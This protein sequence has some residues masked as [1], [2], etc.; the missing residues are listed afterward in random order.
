MN[1]TFTPYHFDSERLNLYKESELLPLRANE[2][3]LLS[4]LLS[5]TSRI[6]SKQEIL[7]YVWSDK[8]VSEQG[9]FQS[10]STLRTML[11]ETSIKTFPRRGYQW[12][13]PVEVEVPIASPSEPDMPKSF[14]AQ[15]FGYF[16]E[17]PVAFSLLGVAMIVVVMTFAYFFLGVEGE[18]EELPAEPELVIALLPFTYANDGQQFDGKSAFLD[19][20]S[21]RVIRQASDYDGI[22]F[23]PVTSSL[24]LNDLDIDPD[25]AFKGITDKYN[26]D[27]LLSATIRRHEADYVS[28]FRLLGNR[29]AWNGRITAANLPALADKLLSNIVL[30]SSAPLLLTDI[31]D[32]NLI[33]AQLRLLHNQR[34][35]NLIVILRLSAHLHSLGD[36]SSAVILA[37]KLLALAQKNNEPFYSALARLRLTYGFVEQG[38]LEKAKLFAEEAIASLKHTQDLQLYAES[39]IAKAN[40]LDLEGNYS[41]SMDVMRESLDI[42]QALDL[43]LREIHLLAHMAAIAHYNK[44]PEE[45]GNWLTMA[46]SV[47]DESGLPEIHLAIVDFHAGKF[48]ASDDIAE[49]H[50]RRVL[51]ILGPERDWWEKEST[52][53]ALTLLLVAQQRWQEAVDI[54]RDEAATTDAENTML[55]Y[56][57]YSWGKF[58]QAK[59]LALQAYRRASISGEHK[60]TLNAAILLS[61]MSDTASEKAIYDDFITARVN[62]KGQM[63]TG[64]NVLKPNY[65][66]RYWQPYFSD[67][68]QAEL[69]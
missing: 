33:S 3:K 43:P 20:I 32:V 60:I 34:P 38:A 15:H 28:Q 68:H 59:P 6:F 4:L 35:T 19:K 21:E 41:A 29:N 36:Y 7:S 53:H 58:E 56:I 52:Q 25:V 50:Y 30:L 55:A 39:L 26:A 2:A 51:K 44:H 65:L 13:L 17:N 42:I 45:V 67:T 66:T 16:K 49:Q 62:D 37:E 12:Q 11:G 69:E 8:V 61:R 57:Y 40:I 10:I 31:S 54:F 27:I 1:Y 18:S 5:D 9:V 47:F 24:A 46:K 23:V 64:K 48:S 22:T 14:V 63:K